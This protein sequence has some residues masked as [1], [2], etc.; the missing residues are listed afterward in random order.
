MAGYVWNFNGIISID[1][2][3]YTDLS[4]VVDNVSLLLLFFNAVCYLFLLFV[5]S[6]FKY[7]Q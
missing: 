4:I 1:M 7:I 3:F 5:F 6:F 2:I